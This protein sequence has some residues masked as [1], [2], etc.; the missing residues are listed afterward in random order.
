VRVVA[1]TTMN[2]FE[3][4]SLSPDGR[5]VVFEWDGDPLVGRESADGMMLLYQTDI[6]AGPLLSQPLS[7]GPPRHSLPA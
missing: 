6:G 3:A 7:G 2:G 1:L 4:G 5:Q